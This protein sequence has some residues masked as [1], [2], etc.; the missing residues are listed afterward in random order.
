MN[1]TAQAHLEFHQQRGVGVLNFKNFLPQPRSQSGQ[2]MV[3][4]ALILAVLIGLFIGAFEIMTL[5][6]KRTDLEAATRLGAREASESWVTD[7]YLSSPDDFED[8]IAAYVRS[9]L[10]RMGYTDDW[11]NGTDNVFDNTFPSSD[12]TIFVEV[13]AFELASGASTEAT[14]VSNGSK[15]CTYGEYIKVTVT[16]RWRFAVLPINTLLSSNTIDSGTMS[17]ELLLRCWRGA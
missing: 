13:E 11:M 2:G 5:F 4:F 9:E 3:E 1:S 7:T 12:D 8:D 6:R 17:E 10:N 15:L 16:M 14:L